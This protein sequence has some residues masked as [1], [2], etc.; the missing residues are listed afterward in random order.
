VNIEVEVQGHTDLTLG[1]LK[2]SGN[3]QRRRRHFLLFH[4]TFLLGFDIALVEAL[5]PPPSKQPG[6]RQHRSHTNFLSN[7][8]QPA[9]TIKAAL[10]QTWDANMPGTDIP[11]PQIETL[12]RNKYATLE[13]SFKF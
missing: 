13:W 2:F 1:G 12:V 4:G 9:A 10:A 8:H 5:L 3:S 6:Y 11:R 7:L